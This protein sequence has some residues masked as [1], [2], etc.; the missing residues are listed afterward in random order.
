MKTI[1][2]IIT[3][4]MLAFV[5]TSCEDPGV[6]STRLNGDEQN[7]PDELKG[8]KVYRVSTGDL[9][10]VKVAI[11]DGKINSTTYSKGKHQETLII[12]DKESEDF[13]EVKEI[14]MENDSLIVCRK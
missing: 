12:I 10:Y 5:F 2:T 13:I 7:L 9:D 3:Y 11:L 6:T 4:A 8:L 14:L 1:T